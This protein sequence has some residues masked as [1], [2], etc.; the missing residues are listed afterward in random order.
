MKNIIRF[1]SLGFVTLSLALLTGCF[2]RTVEETN[3]PPA[4]ASVVVPAPAESTTTTT[5]TGNGAVER[6]STTTYSVP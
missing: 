4:S 2:S 1:G 5:T 6:Q 3:T